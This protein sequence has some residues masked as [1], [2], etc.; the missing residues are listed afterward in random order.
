MVNNTPNRTWYEDFLLSLRFILKDRNSGLCQAHLFVGGVGCGGYGG[1][2]GGV[3]TMVMVGTVG[4]TMVI[5]TMEAVVEGQLGF[6]VVVVAEDEDE[7]EEDGDGDGG[8][9]SVLRKVCVLPS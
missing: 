2:G 3:V 7:D 9:T 8:S 5:H 6:G 1:G 4:T